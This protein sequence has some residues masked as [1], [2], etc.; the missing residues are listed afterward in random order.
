MKIAVL[1]PHRDDAAFSLSLTIGTWL[2]RGHT[3]EVVNCFTRSEYAPFSNVESRPPGDRVTYVTGL[4]M[5]EDECWN[6]QYEAK[7]RPGRLKF[8]DLGLKDAPLR[9]NCSASEVCSIPMNPADRAMRKIHSGLQ[10]SEAGAVVLPLALGGHVDH[11]TARKAFLAVS[12]SGLPYAFYEDLPYATRLSGE[13][14]IGRA[15]HEIEAGLEEFFLGVERD[16]VG[17]AV[18]RKLRLVQCYDS[19]ISDEMAE[20]IAAF[21]ARYGGRERLWAG[22]AWRDSEL[23]R[24][25]MDTGRGFGL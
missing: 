2:D 18:L 22:A 8:K 4:R 1:S 16:D 25:Q 21:A 10:Q 14:D 9:L 20:G 23:V 7:R 6:M 15:A 13:A 5:K 19:Q 12:T 11:R 24:R 17:A 3:V